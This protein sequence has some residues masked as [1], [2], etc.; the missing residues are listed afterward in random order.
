M[1][2]ET[3]TT[4]VDDAA[5]KAGIAALADAQAQMKRELERLQTELSKS[6]SK[7][8]GNAR[9]YYQKVQLGWTDRNNEL[10][11]VVGKTSTTLEE[12]R[13]R[14]MKNEQNVASRWGG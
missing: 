14:Y 6:M 11:R 1:A 8:R 3:S 13:I 10:A 9:E 7:W 2:D 4:V 5:M 12:I